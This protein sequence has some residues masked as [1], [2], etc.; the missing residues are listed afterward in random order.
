M[1][2]DSLTL[3]FACFQ[4]NVDVHNTHY[5]GHLNR[6]GEGLVNGLDIWV[7]GYNFV[8]LQLRG[9]FK[10]HSRFTDLSWH[11]KLSDR[12]SEACNSLKSNTCLGFMAR[13]SIMTCCLFPQLHR[14]TSGAN[15]QCH[16]LSS[17][18]IEE[19]RFTE[20]K[21]LLNRYRVL[22]SEE[23]VG[24]WGV[25]QASSTKFCGSTVLQILALQVAIPGSGAEVAMTSVKNRAKGTQSWQ[26]WLCRFDRLTRHLEWWPARDRLINPRNAMNILFI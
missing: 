22:M 14:N 9:H 6:T 12:L 18:V 4:A 7:H 17:Y 16:L 25:T 13:E 10:I 3:D 11:L 24:K 21:Q 1:E 5:S 19:L 15:S 20:K 23:M 8:Y 26:R 2:K